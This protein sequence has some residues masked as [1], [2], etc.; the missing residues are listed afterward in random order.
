MNARQ[1][2]QDW[3]NLVLGVWLFIAPMLGVGAATGVAAGNAYILGALVVIFSVWALARPEKWEEWVNLVLGVWIIIAPFILGF[4]SE[5]VGAAWNHVIVGIIIAADA[6]WA[7][8]Q[9]Q[10]P[11]GPAGQH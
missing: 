6:V 1:R 10:S 8:S 5:S 2:W 7:A 3:V 9:K 11:T 4:Y